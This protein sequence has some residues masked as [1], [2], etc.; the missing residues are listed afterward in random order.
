MAQHHTANTPQ[1]I[2]ANSTRHVRILSP[3]PFSTHIHS[4]CLCWRG[5][6]RSR[7]RH[8]QHSTRGKTQHM[9]RHTAKQEALDTTASMRTDNNKLRLLGGCPSNNFAS[10]LAGHHQTLL[11]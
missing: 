9:L 8:H 4:V 7:C 10:R 2:D 11:H 5:S 3:Y 6:N 1:T